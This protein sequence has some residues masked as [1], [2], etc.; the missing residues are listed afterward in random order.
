MRTLLTASLLAIL[1]TGITLQE[2]FAGE[3]EV[4]VEIPRLRVS[5]Y[6]RPYVAVWIQDENNRVAANLAVWYQLKH[7]TDQ[8]ANKMAS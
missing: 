2:S 5:E 8:S 1:G 7:P 4:T 6:H 3:L